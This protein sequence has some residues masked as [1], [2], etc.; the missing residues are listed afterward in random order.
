VPYATVSALEEWLAPEPAPAN[1]VRLLTRASTAID[2]A[3]HGLAYDRTDP[4][5]LKTLSDACVQQVQ[6]VIDRGDET[7]ALEDVQSMSTGQRSFTRRAPRNDAGGQSARLCRAA[8]DVLIASGHF[9]RFV[10]VEG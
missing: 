4:D 9:D 8:A 10:W 1:A 6:W 2:R 3:L 5:V 7:G